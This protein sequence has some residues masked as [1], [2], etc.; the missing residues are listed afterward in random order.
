MKK[1]K[2]LIIII[3]IIIVLIL[4]NLFGITPIIT[5]VMQ[6]ILTPIQETVWN[7]GLKIKFLLK[8]QPLEELKQENA[9]LQQKLQNYL[10]DRVELTTLRQ[11]N[12]FL[13]QELN[14][15]ET[16]NYKYQIVRIIGQESIL[17]KNFFILNKG[18]DSGIQEGYP[19]ILGSEKGA[20]GYLIG[21]IIQSENSIS[22]LGLITAPQSLVA[23]KIL[24]TNTPGLVKGERGLTLK[25]DLIPADKKIGPGDIV[26]TSGLESKIPQDL[27]IGEVEAVISEPADFFSQAKIKPFIDFDNLKIVTVLLPSL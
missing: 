7:L 26:V 1:I 14:F 3:S 17:G 13:R 2:F 27:L 10:I 19:V 4:L 18:K 11:E 5:K 6:K 23:A 8:T 16:T 15:L 12:K 9:H 22:K 21:K 20:K 25:M 24:Q